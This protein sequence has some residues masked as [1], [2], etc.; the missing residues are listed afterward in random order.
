MSS[1]ALLTAL[2][3]QSKPKQQPQLVLRTDTS[4]TRNLKLS[5]QRTEDVRY[6]M[7]LILLLP[8]NIRP[9]TL[10]LFLVVSCYTGSKRF[11]VISLCVCVTAYLIAHCGI[12]MD[13]PL[14]GTV[15]ARPRRALC[16]CD[17]VLLFLSL[18]DDLLTAQPLTHGLLVAHS[19]LFIH[20][21]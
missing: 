12:M 6:D 2:R 18:A 3:E 9:S 11:T 8:N 17:S 1:C 15:H 20:L 16:Q 5:L 19:D 21:R 13:H 10:L 4:N 7:I 14:S